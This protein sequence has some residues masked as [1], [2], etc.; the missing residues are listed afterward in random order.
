[1]LNFL[2]FSVLGEYVKILF[3]YS[4][5]MFSLY[6]LSVIS[7]NAYILFRSRKRLRINKTNKKT[8]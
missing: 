3:A 5:N 6:S 4:P 2:F 7:V 1:M 8:P